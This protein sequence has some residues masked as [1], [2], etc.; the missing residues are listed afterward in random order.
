MCFRSWRPYAIRT[1]AATPSSCSRSF[2]SSTT[3][4]TGSK[5][6]FSLSLSHSLYFSPYL[7]LSFYISIYLSISLFISFFLSLSLS[8]THTLRS[9]H[10]YPPLLIN[11]LL[12]LLTPSLILFIIL[13]KFFAESTPQSYWL[14]VPSSCN[15]HHKD[16]KNKN[17]IFDYRI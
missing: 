12:S 6:V 14:S 4:C 8:H 7:S 16:K 10:L 3:P 2:P 15:C 1:R 5:S 17:Y 9:L 11:L 13:L